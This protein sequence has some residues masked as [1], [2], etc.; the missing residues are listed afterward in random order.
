MASE[1]DTHEGPD[2]YP[3]VG[4]EVTAVLVRYRSAMGALM[5]PRL[6][7][8]APNVQTAIPALEMI[9]L[10]KMLGTGSLVLRGFGG[11]ASG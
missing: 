9:R 5:I 3:A 1:T 7:K 8:N 6:L 10:N 11:Q 2:T 4:R